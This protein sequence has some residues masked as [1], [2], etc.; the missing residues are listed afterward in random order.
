MTPHY[1][2]GRSWE[3]ISVTASF[4]QAALNTRG[5][6]AIVAP[7]WDG[8]QVRTFKISLAVGVKPERVERMRGA[9]AIAAGVRAC[10]ISRS[11]GYLLAEIAKV[12]K[13]RQVLRA[14]RLLRFQPE[15]PWRVPIGVDTTGH[16]VWFDLSDER[17]CHAVLGGTTRSGKSNLLHWILFRLLAQNSPR[18]L[19]LLLMDPKG[20]EMAPFARVRHLIHPPE[21]RP[22][23]ILA[24]LLWVQDLMAQRSQDHVTAPRVLVVI[25][26]VREL[27]EREH[28]V[29]KI[30]GSIAQIGAG[31]GVHLLVT[32]QQ[33]GAKSLG[34]ALP[35]FPARLLGRV[36]SKTLTY[37]AAGR[38]KSQAHTLLGRGDFLLIT[39]EDLVRF[40]APLMASEL[41]DRLPKT[42]H[43][44]R[45]QDLGE[46]LDMS[47]V[48]AADQ[49]GGHNRKPLDMERVRRLVVD[50]GMSAG[51][52]SHALGI[53]YER[54]QRLVAVT[55][56]VEQGASA[57][58]I[59]YMFEIGLDRARTLVR[60]FGGDDHGGD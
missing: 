47:V 38:A 49:R 25:D 52:L 4:M 51:Q 46:A 17:T 48:T 21:N 35:N 40:Q 59:S 11:D 36:A 14:E 20:F 2:T 42:K 50:E 31:L 37:G 45:L 56:A 55:R 3:S 1:T 32:T 57:T 9:L 16:L 29:E 22:D 34:E 12:P 33:P 15:T 24:L 26:E 8:P 58:S 43:V 44:S 53:F 30:L 60:Q 10:R 19:Q 54:A 28:R 27:V 18:H 5:V 7:L 13:E 23:E 41:V 39:H 6:N